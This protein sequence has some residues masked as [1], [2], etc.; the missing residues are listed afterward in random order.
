LA[1]AHIEFK[2]GV[3][4]KVEDLFRVEIV[5]DESKFKNQEMSWTF[6]GKQRSVFRRLRL[7]ETKV[8]TFR[9]ELSKAGIFNV[10][11]IT[12]IVQE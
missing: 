5:A 2:V 6:V 9:V 10:N 8:A 7:G 3:T 11:Q 12:I 1:A 4:C